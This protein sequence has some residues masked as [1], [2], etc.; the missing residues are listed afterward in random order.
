MKTLLLLLCFVLFGTHL[1]GQNKN[2]PSIEVEAAYMYYYFDSYKNIPINHSFS[3]LISNHIK[4]LKVSI[5]Y[6]YATKNYTY[7]PN[8]ITIDSLEKRSY[9]TKFSNFPILLTYTLLTEKSLSHHIV[10]GVVFNTVSAYTIES[11][12]RSR[13]PIK[14]KNIDHGQQLGASLTTGYS[15]KLNINP[16][17]SLNIKPFI[18]YQIKPHF[19]AQRPDY[20][21]FPEDKLSLG[22]KLGLEY[23]F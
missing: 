8:I 6:S 13:S 21:N 14:E 1:S 22:F 4:K 20:R 7:Q 16:H 23:S 5:G 10:F 17:I 18:N 12:Y 2:Q 11:C 9:I 19:R 15:M 3:F